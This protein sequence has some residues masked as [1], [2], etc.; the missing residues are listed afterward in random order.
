MLGCL[1]DGQHAGEVGFA[2]KAAEGEGGDVWGGGDVAGVSVAVFVHGG[3]WPFLEL[4]Y[5]SFLALVVDLGGYYSMGVVGGQLFCLGICVRGCF[6]GRVVRI[7]IELGALSELA[8]ACGSDSSASVGGG[9]AGGKV[10]L[11]ACYQVGARE[12]GVFRI[13]GG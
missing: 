13:C 8:L 1:E 11:T 9:G 3:F 4:V 10:V 12:W 2:E 6:S 7:G 5:V